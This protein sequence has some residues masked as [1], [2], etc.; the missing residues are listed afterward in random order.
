MYVSSNIYIYIN[1]WRKIEI[2]LSVIENDKNVYQQENG[3][4]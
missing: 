2:E 3:Q 4:F 1:V